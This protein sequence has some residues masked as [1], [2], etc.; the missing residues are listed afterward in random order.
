MSRLLAPSV[1][2]I[3]QDHG[4][5][6][7]FEP[8]AKPCLRRTVSLSHS[9][10]WH[11][12]LPQPAVQPVCVRDTAEG[13]ER[14]GEDRRSLSGRRCGAS[15]LAYVWTPERL[16][17]AGGCPPLIWFGFNLYKYIKMSCVLSHIQPIHFFLYIYMLIKEILRPGL[18]CFIRAHKYFLV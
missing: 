12:F 5:L 11:R 1:F 18:M 2:T 8:S 17:V 9:N 7:P 10:C 13:Q 15:V 3:N 6:E 14:T 16:L 4:R